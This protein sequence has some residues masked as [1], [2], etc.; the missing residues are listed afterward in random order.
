MDF[1][2]VK[3]DSDFISDIPFSISMYKIEKYEDIDIREDASIYIFYIKEGNGF[4]NELRWK[5]GDL[6]IYPYSPNGIQF[7][8]SNDTEI[9]LIHNS[10]LLESMGVKPYR[11]LFEPKNYL[12]NDKIDSQ[13]IKKFFLEPEKIETIHLKKNTCILCISDCFSKVKSYIQQKEINWK[14]G[15]VIFIRGGNFLTFYSKNNCK[16]IFLI[17][18]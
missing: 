17:I 6:F 4:I 5:K 8:A 3:N 1:F 15:K 11:P 13:N 9:F 7:Y 10:P 14:N 2:E 16:D 18:E 12:L